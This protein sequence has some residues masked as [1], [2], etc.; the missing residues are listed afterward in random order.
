MLLKNSVCTRG[1]IEAA[2][3][4]I[5]PLGDNRWVTQAAVMVLLQ[6]ALDGLRLALALHTN[7]IASLYNKTPLIVLLPLFLTPSSSS[8]HNPGD[9]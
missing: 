7:V 8:L 3:E 4:R 1:V 9:Q 2:L 5:F 6:V